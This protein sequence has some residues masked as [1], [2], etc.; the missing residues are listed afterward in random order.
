MTDASNE[1]RRSSAVGGPGN[2][3]DPDRIDPALV[4]PPDLDE[5][6]G[7]R[8]RGDSAAGD[9]SPGTGAPDQ[10][11]SAGASNSATIDR[12]RDGATDAGRVDRGPND[13]TDV[14]RTSV[15]RD[16][17]G[18]AD[19]PKP[20]PQQ[21]VVERTRTSGVWVAS[22]LFAV[23]LVLLLIFALQ[24]NN[25]VDIAF[26]G[27]QAQLPLGVA[28]LFAATAGALL[29]AIAGT[30]RVLQLRRVAKRHRNLDRK[31]ATR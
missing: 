14:E 29:V 23:V 21:H 17:S 20:P 24:N 4:P 15:D 22:V 26:L 16:A 1:S 8:T 3:S 19:R 9:D 12:P 6:A 27:W 7:R 30:A 10:G 31:S 11:G 13:S 5:P 25:R 18:V 2:P 28:L